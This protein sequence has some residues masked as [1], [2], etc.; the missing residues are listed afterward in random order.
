MGSDYK[1]DKGLQTRARWRLGNLALYFFQFSAA[2]SV[3]IHT[4][5]LKNIVGENDECQFLTAIARLK[6][7]V[8]VV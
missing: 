5:I 7:N 1:L 3:C 2:I 6:R 8:G 4:A